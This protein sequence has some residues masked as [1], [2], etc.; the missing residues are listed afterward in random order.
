MALKKNQKLSAFLKD[1]TLSSTTIEPEKSG[2]YRI[3]HFYFDNTGKI[4]RKSFLAENIVKDLELKEQKH[5]PSCV[6]LASTY[7]YYKGSNG[8]FINFYSY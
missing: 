1:T 7:F 5:F 3:V 4:R 8:Y 6:P 2:G